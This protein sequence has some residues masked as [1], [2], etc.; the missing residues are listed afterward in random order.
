MATV[1]QR[2][3]EAIELQQ[4]GKLEEAVGRLQALVTDQPDYALAHAA[5]RLLRQVG[6]PR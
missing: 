1:E 3:D 4:Q 6:P 5:E 2:Y